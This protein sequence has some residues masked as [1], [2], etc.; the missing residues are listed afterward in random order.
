MNVPDGWTE[1]ALGEILVYEQPYRYSVSSTDYDDK[2]GTPVLTA[3]KSFIL[4]YTTEIEGIYE[5]LP[6]IILMTSRR[7]ASM[8]IFLSK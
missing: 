8:S 3:G 6:V 5:N 4:G 1:K 7:I 2:S